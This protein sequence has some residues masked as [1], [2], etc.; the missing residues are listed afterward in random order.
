[1]ENKKLYKIIISIGL[2]SFLFISSAVLYNYYKTFYSENT[3]FSDESVFI[4]IKSGTG[5]KSLRNE[6]SPYIKDTSTFFKAAYKTKFIMNIKAGKYELKKGFSNKEIINSLR[7][8]N[9]PI[10]ITFNNMERIENL[11][12]RVSKFIEADSLSLMNSFNNEVF[13]EN[14]N[15]NTES[16]FSIFLPNTYEFYWNTSADEFIDFIENEQCQ[17]ID[18]LGVEGLKKFEWYVDEESNT[19][20]LIEEFDNADS[21]KEIATKAIGTPVNLKFREITNFDNM[22][23]LGD[24]SDEMRE[25]LSA[26]GPKIK[27]Y[28][29]G[30]N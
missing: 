24:V 10:K 21:F 17:F 4:Y 3:N 6:I 14:N 1:M 28:K 9:I 29:A 2:L 7:F 19:A 30:L 26:M 15:L 13:L 11:A 27:T 12:S 25:N 22:T 16:V 5:L 8:K 20:T 18:S 23:I